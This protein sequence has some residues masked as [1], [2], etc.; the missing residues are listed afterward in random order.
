MNTLKSNQSKNMNRHTRQYA[1]RGIIFG[2]FFPVI[3]S[4]LTIFTSNMPF[5]L[6]SFI[7]IQIN[8]PLM[9]VIDTAPLVLG[10]MA[11]YIG[12][13]QD[14][15]EATNQELRLREFESETYQYDLEQQVNKRTEELILANEKSTHRLSQFEGITRV[16]HAVSSTDTQDELLPQI[17][18]VISEQLGFYHV[19]IFLI[20]EAK[21]YAVL[22][23]ANSDGGQKML[24]RHHKLRIGGVGIVGNVT[25]TGKPRIALDVGL[26]AVFFTNP[27]LPDTHSEMALPLRVGAETFGALDVQSI[28]KNAFGSD[29]INILSI[30]ADLVSVA[31]QNAKFRQQSSDAI[32]RAES[33]AA[34]FGEQQWRNFHDYEPISGYQFNGVNIQKINSTEKE[35]AGQLTIPLKLRGVQIGTLKISTTEQERTWTEDEIAIAEATAERTALAVENARLIREAQKRASKEKTIGEIA[36]KLGSLVNIENIVQTTIQEL[37]NNL[38]GTEIAI[39]FKQTKLEK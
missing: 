33:A 7:D 2:L 35:E 25:K 36:S 28:E 9:W 24:E 12:R 22:V 34:Q 17:T 37:G 23:A 19:G 4:I 3:G 32:A 8:N 26:D 31:I 38:P 20:D 21:E 1:I 16:V 18:N 11:A 29:D 30:L 6:G 27:D 39:Q 13:R 10:V 14:V 15:L 5:S